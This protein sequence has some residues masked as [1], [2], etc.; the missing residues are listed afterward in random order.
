MDSN[1]LVHMFFLTKPN[2][3]FSG[4]SVPRGGYSNRRGRP[5]LDGQGMPV[6][7]GKRPAPTGPPRMTVGNVVGMHHPPKKV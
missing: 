7:P 5:Y 2:L 4:N 6:Y 1:I 3:F